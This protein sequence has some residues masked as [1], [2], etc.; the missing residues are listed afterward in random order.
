MNENQDLIF[1]LDIGTR[2]VVGVVFSQLQDKLIIEDSEILEH[3]Q[4]SMLD[5]QIHNVAEVTNQVQKIKTRLED[6]LSVKLNQVAIA[7]A[8]RALKTV[9]GEFS[10]KFEGNKKVTEEDIKTL[11]FTAVQKA[12]EDLV[13]VDEKQSNG[14]HF[15]GYS[16]IR[17]RLDGMEINHLVGQRGTEIEVELVA[18]FLP[19]VVVDSLLTVIKQSDLEVEHL[20]LEPIAASNL[21]IPQQMHGFNLALVDIGAGTSDIAVTEDGAI[22]GYAMVP[23]AGDEITEA[24]CNA[25]MVDYRTAERIKRSLLDKEV[26]EIKDILD[27]KIEIPTQEVLTKIDSKVEHLAE[28]IA[29]EIMNLNEQEPQAVICFGG[30]SLSPL[31]RDK[32][33]QTLE[34]PINRVGI[35]SSQDSE[36]IEGNIEELPVIQAITPLGIGLSSYHNQNQANFLDV[37]VNGELVHLFTLSEPEISDALLAAEIDLRELEPSL[38]LALTVEVKDEVKVIPGETGTPGE[39][40]LNGEVAS[41]D[42]QIENEDEIQVEFGEESRQGQGVI[43]DVVPKLESK[44]IIINGEPI[45]LEPKYYLDDE[46]VE[47]DTPLND[48]AQIDYREVE[49]VGDVIQQVWDIPLHLL[50]DKKIRY[51]INGEEKE[52]NF[53]NYQVKLN[54]KEVNL[55]TRV[56]SDD[57]LFFKKF[58]K[59][60]Q[61]TLTVKDALENV[62]INSELKIILNGRELEIPIKGFE[63]LKNGIETTFDTEIVSGDKITYQAGELI[64][65]QVLD[66][67]N[68]NLS[69]RNREK[70]VLKKNGVE[71]EL[72][73]IVTQGDKIDIYLSKRLANKK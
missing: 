9:K 69:E 40:L 44:E 26:V 35:K 55:D 66:H 28:L 1:A 42:T 48:R 12:Q 8:G 19:R 10:I 71:V 2:T 6:R 68:Y 62:N 18:T 52:Y 60:N 53:S 21:L 63:L 20:T 51:L 73:D 59:S 23:V 50:Q 15:V 11:E 56:S 16:V 31:L 67:I 45:V 64:I 4:R 24:I 58:K 36:Q 5:G 43:E 61:H 70:M 33:A 41:L 57:N 37:K 72:D 3:Q 32:L 27:Q 30:G 54:D 14:Y 46:L 38:G 49:T 65:E 22:I 25:Y 29:E 17:S 7:A 39:L 34:M 47:L 13:A